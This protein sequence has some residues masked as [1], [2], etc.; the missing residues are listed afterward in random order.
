[1][2]SISPERSDETRITIPISASAAGSDSANMGELWRRE[3]LLSSCRICSHPERS[4]EPAPSFAQ[5]DNAGNPR[6]LS[7]AARRSPARP[8]R[9]A[10]TGWR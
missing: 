5:D 9:R 1:V 7:A 8:R 4:E 2:R 6:R 3:G 10:S